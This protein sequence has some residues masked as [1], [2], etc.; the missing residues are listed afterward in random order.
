MEARDPSGIEQ[1][2]QYEFG[3]Q[4]LLQKA[5]RHSSYV[6]ELADPNLKDNELSLIHI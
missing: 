5:L 2:L 3:S 6:N 1:H 4:E